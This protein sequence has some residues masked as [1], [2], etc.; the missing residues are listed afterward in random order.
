MV[1]KQELREE[2]EPVSQCGSCGGT[3]YRHEKW[4]Q[5]PSRATVSTPFGGTFTHTKSC[6]KDFLLAVARYKS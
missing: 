2:V 1:T 5:C 4:F 3:V 6:P